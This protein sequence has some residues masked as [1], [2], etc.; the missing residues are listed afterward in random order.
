MI[1]QQALFGYREGHNLVTASIELKPFERQFLAN[2]TDG[3]G[4][5]DS[6]AFSEGITGL[7][8]PKSDYYALFCTWAAPEMPRPGCVWS[9][10]LLLW[11][12][13]IAVLSD[14]GTLRQ[15]FMRPAVPVFL[16][17]YA[18]PLVFDCENF[19]GSC[20]RSYSG[21][22]AASLVKAIYTRPQEGIVVLTDSNHFWEDAVFA[23]WSQQW[24]R[25]RRNFTFS[26]ASFGDRRLIG[27]RFDLQIA[28]SLNKRIWNRSGKPTYLLLPSGDR[29][30]K[31]EEWLQVAVDDLGVL[32]GPL[33][34][35][36]QR[37]GSDVA[38]PR[39]GF[40]AL[41]ENFVRDERGA[42]DVGDRLHSVA[43]AFPSQDDAL[44]LKR[45][46]VRQVLDIDE[47]FRQHLL[48]AIAFLVGSDDAGA[49]G[50][51][52]IDYKQYVRALWESKRVE[53]L[54][55]ATTLPTSRQ[56]QLLV[57]DIADCV[58][59]FD[60]PAIW[61]QQPAAMAIVV[62][63][64]PEV[65]ASPEAWSMD[66]DGQLQ[67]WTAVR[68]V[69][70]DPI[71][72]ADIL[73]AMLVVRLTFFESE[74]V[75]LCRGSLIDG[76]SKWLRS[77]RSS[78]PSLAWRSALQ[79]SL[80]DRIRSDGVPGPVLAFAGITVPPAIARSISG[81]RK[82]IQSLASTEW[83]DL[84]EWLRQ[85]TLFW[86]VSVGLSTS[87]SSG[88]NI[89]RNGF[90]FVYDAVARS[91]YQSESWDLIEPHLPRPN[92]GWA[93]DRCR[94]LRRGLKRWK[95]ENPTFTEALHGETRDWS[96]ADDDSD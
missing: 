28:P 93:W 86:L 45:D 54:F 16:P 90:Q 26:T 25:L 65:A 34:S 40:I 94:Q 32:N 63:R 2:V 38:N 70:T 72:W 29:D 64:R 44:S 96:V 37:Y 15:L 31:A 8:V 43:T 52:K 95:K 73:K 46:V 47:Q 9:H 27:E 92:F 67:L 13:D 10:V 88:A 51:V 49:F 80:T 18:A 30:Y 91:Q 33:R 48:E 12:A 58:Q 50:L 83:K 35:Y 59:D 11:L 61:G 60:V 69:S 23:I 7:P 20:V 79:P 17:D 82:D 57:S 74:T 85:K 36:L 55:L 3:S 56:A 4:P 6:T 71:L 19:S 77:S 89:L 75:A 41:V 39:R 14:L 22:E 42:G 66:V 81:R 1:I 62:K 5:I 76:L 53:L 21:S 84:P 78:L 87:G 68:E 24:P